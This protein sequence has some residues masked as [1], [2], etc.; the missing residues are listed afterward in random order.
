MMIKL[1]KPVKEELDGGWERD[2]VC[3][4]DEDK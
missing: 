1:D 3:K 2:N 4:D